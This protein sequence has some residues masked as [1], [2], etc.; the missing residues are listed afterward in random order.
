MLTNRMSSALLPA[1]TLSHM[2]EPSE[3]FKLNT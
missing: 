2:T 1:P 3:K